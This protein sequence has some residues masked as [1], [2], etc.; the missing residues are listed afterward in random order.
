MSQIAKK[1]NNVFLTITCLL[2]AMTSFS[3]AK[4][5]A[6][7]RQKKTESVNMNQ[8]VST[9]SE[10]LAMNQTLLYKIATISQPEQTDS[11]V[12][13]ESDILTPANQYLPITTRHENGNLYSQG[14]Y[15]DASKGAQVKIE[16]RCTADDCSKYT[17]L[18][19]VY[20]NNAVVFQN[21]A[22]SYKDDCKFY[23]VSTTNSFQNLDAFDSYVQRS[24]FSTPRNDCVNQGM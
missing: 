17:M 23:T 20:R 1:N 22:V 18:V 12:I 13:V 14:V 6:G 11:G 19:S 3:C 7:V 24:S 5:A 21:A 16:S 15:Q 2:L 10:Q 9:Q 8:M 4:K